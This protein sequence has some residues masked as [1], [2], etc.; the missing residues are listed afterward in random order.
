VSNEAGLENKVRE[1]IKHLTELQEIDDELKDIAAER[2]D[3]PEEV[4]KLGAKIR[5]FEAFLLERT[6]QLEETEKLL[7]ASNLTLEEG[8]DK[9]T[10]LQQQLYAVKTTREYDAIT[11][12]TDFIKAEIAKS[13]AEIATATHRKADLT[14][15]IEE[16]KSDLAKVRAEEQ[17][18]AEELKE[19]MAETEADERQL[20]HRRE[21][22]VVRI[23]KPLYNHYERIRIAKDGRGVARILDGA[24]GGCFAVI[25]PQIQVNIRKVIDIVLCET[26]GRIL[27]P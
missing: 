26:C 1:A 6:A 22:V 10:K 11:A 9:L 19:K 2:G 7:I 14:K 25:P 17:V 24:C 23:Q 27:V 12:E 3:L 8:K 5:E 20:L 13:E 15:L 16:R 18:K 4:E 21:N